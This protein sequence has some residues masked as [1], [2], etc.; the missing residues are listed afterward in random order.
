MS[1][2]SFCLV[3]GRRLLAP[4]PLAGKLAL[5]VAPVLPVL[6]LGLASLLMGRPAPLLAWSGV[7]GGG[8]S[9]YLGLCL[10]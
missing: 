9:L 5:L 7:V 2:L 8:L 6:L 4:W 10:A 3:P 1:S